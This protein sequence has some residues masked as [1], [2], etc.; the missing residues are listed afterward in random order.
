VSVSG[1]LHKSKDEL[2]ACLPEY[3]GN[4]KSE[5]CGHALGSTDD[6]FWLANQ[7]NGYQHTGLF[8]TWNIST[9]ISEYSVLAETETDFQATVK[10]AG[11]H[12]LRLVVK[13]T[14]E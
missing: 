2:A 10:F 3:G 14:G 7:P 9:D 6:E 1:R 5:A 12:N 11:D 4:I 13:N 8:N